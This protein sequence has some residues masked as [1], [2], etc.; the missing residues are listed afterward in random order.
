MSLALPQADGA[1]LRPLALTPAAAHPL[2]PLL[3]HG[4]LAVIETSRSGHLAQITVLALFDA[5][6]MQAASIF[7]LP[8]TWPSFIPSIAGAKVVAGGPDELYLDVA[9][10]IDVPL[11][12][13]KNVS[14]VQLR[15]D[16]S[17]VEIRTLS[18]QLSHSAHHWQFVPL[19]AQTLVVYSSY[20]DLREASWFIRQ[21]VERSRTVGPAVVLTSAMMFINS[22]R[23]C[24]RMGPSVCRRPGARERYA[25]ERRGG[26]DRSPPPALVGPY[27]A[28]ALGALRTDALAPL[29]AR[30]VVAHI[31][32]DARQRFA[33][34]TVWTHVYEPADAI[35]RLAAQPAN[36][37]GLLPTCVRSD[38]RSDD[39]KV[40]VYELE[41]DVPLSNVV[42]THRMVRSPAEAANGDSTLD[43]TSVGGSRT[44]G[45]W[46]VHPLSGTAPLRRGPADTLLGYALAA[47]FTRDSWVARRMVAREPFFD[48][49]LNVS[50]AFLSVL[51]I[52]G[53]V[54]GW[55]P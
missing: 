43:V 23:W 6:P 46:A 8:H 39:G 25:K 52:R 51:A 31:R 36:Y 20:A 5:S 4:D 49:G 12:N 21:L 24:L 17:V 41:L 2:R 40:A 9:L 32:A 35:Y 45:R 54:E 53:R 7:E 15:R 1:A 44:R 42:Q 33:Q 3:A 48:H 22:L 26:D 55:N 18:G 16:R 29:L 28:D 13:L 11:T 30:G 27:D 14:R 34:A 10:E 37:A 47:D 38:V 50:A 19:G